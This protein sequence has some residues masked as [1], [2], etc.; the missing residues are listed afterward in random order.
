[1]TQDDIRYNETQD[2][3]YTKEKHNSIM[4]IGFE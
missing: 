4:I 2:G 1:M 3:C